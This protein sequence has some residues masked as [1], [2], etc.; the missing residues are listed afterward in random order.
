MFYS[1][2]KAPKKL[3]MKLKVTMEFMF[4]KT[5]NNND[6]PT[7]RQ[8]KNYMSKNNRYKK[9]IIDLFLYDGYNKKPTN[10]TFKNGKVSFLIDQ[11]VLDVYDGIP[12]FPTVQSLINYLN[13]ISLA[14]GMWEGMPGSH[15]VYPDRN[16]N[17]LGVINFGNVI[18]VPC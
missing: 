9:Y 14:D 12:M 11:T 5:S 4:Q 1:F 2:G 8:L 10:I 18:I 3:K 6:S 7:V 13:N 16:K 15:G 17:E